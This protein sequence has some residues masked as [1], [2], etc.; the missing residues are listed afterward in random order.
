[1]RGFYPMLMI[2]I[3]P[4]MFF[5]L[6]THA[7]T[8]TSRV[9]GMVLDSLGKAIPGVNIRLTSLQD[10]LLVASDEKGYF[11]F[12]RVLDRKFTLS[13][14]MLGLQVY[15]NYFNFRDSQNRIAFPPFILYPNSTI[16]KPVDVTSIKPIQVM[17]DTVQYNFA[18]YN[19]GQNVILE[20]ALKKLQNI[21]VLRDGT[22][23]AYGK[24]ISRVQVD[25][26]NF[27]G[28]DVLTAT[29]NL[30]A[31]IIKHIQIIDYYG[32][33]STN[34]G[35]QS[36][37][38]GE[39]VLNIVLQDD[40]K[41]FLFGQLT[42]A[43]GDQDRYIGSLGINSFNNGQE[44]SV[45]ASTNNTNTNLFS[46]GSLTGG[47]RTR[48]ALDLSGLTDPID[49]INQ[50]SAVGVTFSDSIGNLAMNGKYQF[51]QR[52]NTTESQMVLINAFR[53]YKV[54]NREKKVSE[55]NTKTHTFRMDFERNW[56][57][58]HLLKI[59]PQIGYNDQDQNSK[60]L[61]EITNRRIYSDGEYLLNGKTSSPNLELNAVYSYQFNKSKRNLFFEVD[62]R[63]TSQ[64]SLESIGDY[65]VKIDSTDLVPLVDVFSFLQE[66]E[67]DQKSRIGNI[68]AVYVEPMGS[69][70][71]L[72]LSYELDYNVI[73]HY[74]QVQDVENQTWIDSLGMDYKYTYN[75]NRFSMNFQ[76]QLHPQ[77]TY[78][79]GVALQPIDMIGKGIDTYNTARHS[80]L[81]IIPKANFRYKILPHV[82]WSFDYVGRNTQP[83][84]YQLQPVRDLTNSQLVIVGNQNLKSEFNNKFDTRFRAINFD[85]GQFFELHLS[86]TH[87]KNKIVANRRAVPNSTVIE[88]SFLNAQGYYDLRSFY[89]FSTPIWSD[90]LHFKWDGGLDYVNNIS[91]SDDV[92]NISKHSILTQGI[93]F[94]LNIPDH[95]ELESNFNYMYYHSRS[96]V[97]TLHNLKANTLISSVA[98]K[99][100]ITDNLAMGLDFSHQKV[101]GYTHFN[102][103]NPSI[104]NAYVEYSFLKNDMALIRIQGVDI[105]NENA[106][107]T[108][109]VY[110]NIDL[111][112]QNN[113]LGRHILVSLNIRFQRKPLGNS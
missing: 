29:K 70:S 96:D 69:K 5:S 7:Q 3:I 110:D 93:N 54:E 83:S 50:V 15:E 25:G 23:I 26:K 53:N 24:R 1:M 12:K 30:H 82:E 31:D 85:Y 102:H 92:K 44:L 62:L 76:S 51:V 68:R 34:T 38:S 106:G 11:V 41:K 78:V 91:Y 16:L 9:E 71:L 74:R 55:N 97:N 33:E 17:Q 60:S 59:T 22:I 108:K 109:E 19:F 105:F 27:F 98:A 111:S 65:Y 100:Y 47:D 52:K 57:Q 99:S 72:E 18:A 13:F 8:Q 90:Y 75:S 35:I 77:F 43:G 40:K 10:T 58:K 21:Q 4:L 42:T 56:N 32:E 101:S 6:D 14:T 107:I 2:I 81:N 79:L 66:S 61:K 88:T 63:H 104:F 103:L 49:G 94:T 39:K 67:N 46:F 95:L 73:N 80:H 87:A 28:G 86:Y 36:G 45:I 112:M 20:N 64:N 89:S 113:R 37:Q 84:F 48:E